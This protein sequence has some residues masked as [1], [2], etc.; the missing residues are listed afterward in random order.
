[1]SPSVAA[2]LEAMERALADLRAQ[3]RADDQAALRPLAYGLQA[4]PKQVDFSEKKVQDFILD[5]V[6]Q[7]SPRLREI[8]LALYSKSSALEDRQER[9]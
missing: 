2:E 6:K 7:Y 1:M 4:Q 9:A 3:A 8:S 5:Y